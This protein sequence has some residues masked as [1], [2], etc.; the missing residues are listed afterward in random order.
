MLRNL[1]I[2]QKL[3][4]IVLVMATGIPVIFYLIRTRDKATIDF[5]QAERYGC[6]YLAPTQGLLLHALHYRD[7]LDAGSRM[8]E[9]LAKLKPQIEADLAA[10]EAVDQRT[11]NLLASGADRIAEKLQTLRKDWTDLQA[12]NS[13][14]VA[15]RFVN[16]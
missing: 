8:A 14:T 9:D 12:G 3:S 16:D 5:G 2:W 4:L 10:V 1:K 15:D 13:S 7:L 6:N 11:R